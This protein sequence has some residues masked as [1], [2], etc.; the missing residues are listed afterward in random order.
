MQIYLMSVIINLNLY[1]FKFINNENV[2][3]IFKIFLFILYLIKMKTIDF[4][5]NF[6]WKKAL[7]N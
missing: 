3:F 4:S 5:E 6:L 2:F 1:E 7:D